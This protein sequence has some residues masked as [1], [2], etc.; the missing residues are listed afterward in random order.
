MILDEAANYPLP[1]LPSLMSEGGGTGIC[2]VV[3]LQSLAQARHVWGEHAASAVWDA[4]I[5]KVVLGGGSNA[6]DLDDLSRLIGHRDKPR[7]PPAP[8]SAPTGDLDV[9]LDRPGPVSS[10][11]GC[12]PCRSGPRCCCCGPPGRSS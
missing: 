12:G 7:P 5:V 9:D 8:V 3:V 10:R 4:A 2:T 1:S 6:R 11:P